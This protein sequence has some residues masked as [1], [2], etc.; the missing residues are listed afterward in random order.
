MSPHV[1]LGNHDSS[2]WSASDCPVVDSHLQDSHLL[3][4]VILVQKKKRP[5]GTYSYGTRSCGVHRHLRDPPE[6]P[7][8]ARLPRCRSV[9]LP[10][11]Q[12]LRG[13][14]GE[15]E[16]LTRATPA[17]TTRTRPQ[18]ARR[19]GRPQRDRNGRHHLMLLKSNCWFIGENA[20]LLLS[21]LQGNSI[22]K[23]WG[24]ARVPRV[25]ALPHARQ[26][27]AFACLLCRG[28]GWCCSFENLFISKSTEK[29]GGKMSSQYE[30]APPRSWRRSR[31]SR[32]RSFRFFEL[33][34]YR[35]TSLTRK[36]TPLGP[37]GRPIP[38]AL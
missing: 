22:D 16:P 9:V 14:D 37:Y 31:S 17:P 27:R 32:F 1:H 11:H 35:G 7:D 30:W 24:L 19:V 21:L 8:Q 36:R 28:R 10:R 38:G 34:P 5:A 2:R 33:P 6:L 23:A 13:V 12:H 15:P 4:N 3:T 18:G 26:P 29:L 25:L 20:A